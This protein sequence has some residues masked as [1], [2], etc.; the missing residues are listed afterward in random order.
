MKNKKQKGVSDYN[1]RNVRT[2]IPVAYAAAE[3]SYINYSCKNIIHAIFGFN[4]LGCNCMW[5]I[6]FCNI[7]H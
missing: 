4:A 5:K 2:V 1:A 6:S 3:R 7:P